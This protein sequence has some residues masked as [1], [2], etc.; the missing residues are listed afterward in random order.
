MLSSGM[1]YRPRSHH[2][3]FHFFEFTNWGLFLAV[4]IA[5]SV[6]I[7]R[8]DWCVADDGS[9]D[10][11]RPCNTIYSALAFAIVEWILFT[12][13]FFGVGYAASRYRG[14]TGVHEKTTGGNVVRPSDDNTIRAEGTAV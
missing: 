10:H 9:H 11:S 6:N 14:T 13:T 7:G 5:L 3:L 12:M 4:W 8:K 1:Q 2:H